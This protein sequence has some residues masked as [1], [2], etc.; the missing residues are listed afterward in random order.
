MLVSSKHSYSGFN[1]L[2]IF[3]CLKINSRAIF[4][5]RSKGDAATSLEVGKAESVARAISTEVAD[6][7]DQLHPAFSKKARH[8]T[9]FG[10]VDFDYAHRY[11]DSEE[12][13][14]MF[15][16]II[17][18][19]CYDLP[20]SE[21]FKIKDS[22]MRIAEKHATEEMPIELHQLKVSRQ[23]SVTVTVEFQ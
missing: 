6:S 3:I 23:L 16:Y 13:P 12:P 7:F 2:R 8:S 14:E 22:F 10:F 18:G 19:S 1:S 17:E 9:R 5:S 4:R 11:R 15:Y 20:D 21:I